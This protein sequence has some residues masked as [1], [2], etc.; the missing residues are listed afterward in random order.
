MSPNIP[1]KIDKFNNFVSNSFK[2][3]DSS[4]SAAH[5]RVDASQRESGFVAMDTPL[6]WSDGHGCLTK[7]EWT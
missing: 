1:K 5:G 2:V 4:V 6:R 7:G 3:L